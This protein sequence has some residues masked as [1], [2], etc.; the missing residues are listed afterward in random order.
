M[1]PSYGREVMKCRGG[2]QRDFTLQLKN[3]ELD[4]N[5]CCPGQAHSTLQRPIL[6]TVLT[7]TTDEANTGVN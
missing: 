2:V 6:T 7:K 4:G 3:S 1:L 5:A